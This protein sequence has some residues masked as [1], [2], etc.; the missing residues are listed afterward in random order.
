MQTSEEELR[1]SLERHNTVF[2]NLLRLIPARYYIVNDD[3][4]VR[5]PQITLTL[6]PK[7]TTAGFKIS[8][9]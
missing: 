7:S 9:E 3:P 8:E 1:E 6:A 2:E 4:E 5:S